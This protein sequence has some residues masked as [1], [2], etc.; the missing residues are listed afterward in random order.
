MALPTM[1]PG[2]YAAATLLQKSSAGSQVRDFSILNPEEINSEAKP[3]G[4]K[5]YR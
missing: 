2:K 1:F 3:D 4:L 5:W